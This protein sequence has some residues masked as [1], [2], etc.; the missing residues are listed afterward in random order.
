MVVEAQVQTKDVV[1]GRRESGVVAREGQLVEIIKS[2]GWHDTNRCLAE[3]RAQ[4][5]ASKIYS[6]R[7][8]LAMKQIPDSNQIS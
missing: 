7:V 6:G 3:G 1:F 8:E 5:N 2:W 4:S